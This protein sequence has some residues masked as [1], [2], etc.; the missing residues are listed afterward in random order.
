MAVKKVVKGPGWTMQ[1]IS[2][3]LHKET[4]GTFV[5]SADDE[6]AP[7]KT[8]YVAKSAFSNGAPDSITLTLT[9]SN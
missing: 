5:Y 9:E 4:K 7:V 2:M 8:V 6:E 3:N 1:Q